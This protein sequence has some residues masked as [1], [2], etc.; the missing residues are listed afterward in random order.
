MIDNVFDFEKELHL[1][2]ED[3]L[4]SLLRMLYLIAEREASV[5]PA[6]E[7]S[8][9]FATKI[10]SIFN[11]LDENRNREKAEKQ[12][13][14]AQ[15][16]REIHIAVGE[17]PLGSIKVA[18]GKVPGRSERRF[19][20]MND[21]YAIGPL[22]DLTNK[23]D[24]HRRHL[25][26]LDK[27][28]LSEH[29]SYAIQGMDELLRLNSVVS[30]IDEDTRITIWYANNAHE[31][32]GLLYA[33]HLLRNRLGPVYLIET[34]ALYQE[35]FNNSEVQHDV[36]RTGGISSEKLLAMWEHCVNAEPLS[37]EER[38]HME[39]EWVDLAVQPGLLRLMKDGEIQSLPEDAIDEYIMQKARELTLIRQPGEF[40]KSARIVGEVLGHLE[41][42]VGDAFIEYRIRQLIIQR[43]LEM[44]GNPHAMR[45]YSVRLPQ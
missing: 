23:A 37:L 32:T 17:S 33:M 40:I 5:Q 6:E 7:H 15:K 18:M 22:G 29:G 4:R 44:E 2:N 8:D 36:L 14:M 27:L 24:L 30:S 41:Q 9:H 39:Q 34:S 35:L 25:W 31:K 1:M 19:F 11:T 38:R 26:L 12:A 10:Q 13:L 45:F 42:A 21:Y 16:P 20:S 3:E 28:Y 43:R